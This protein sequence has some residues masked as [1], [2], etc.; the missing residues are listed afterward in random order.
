MGTEWARRPHRPA[1]PSLWSYFGPF[2]ACMSTHIMPPLLIPCARRLYQRMGFEVCED[3]MDR[4]W[5]ADAEKGRVGQ[6]RR[7][8]LVR[9]HD[10]SGGDSSSGD[11]S[12]AGGGR[13]CA[14]HADTLPHFFAAE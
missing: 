6:P 13:T 1:V 5:L 14:P 8:L 9:R 11:S 3:Y 12:A 2:L 10:G 4:A 7:L